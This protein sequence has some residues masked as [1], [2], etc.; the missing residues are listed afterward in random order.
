MISIASFRDGYPSAVEPVLHNQA[1]ELELDNMIHPLIKNPV[2]N[3]ISLKGKGALITGSN[4]SEKS[5]FLRTTAVNVILAQTTLHN[6]HIRISRF[7]L[8]GLHIH[9]PE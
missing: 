9:K 1:R 5:T 8:S 7:L 3:S 2:P 6:L 4:M